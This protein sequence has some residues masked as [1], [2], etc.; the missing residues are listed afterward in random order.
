MKPVAGAA[1]E[2]VAGMPTVLPVQVLATNAGDL[3]C[4]VGRDAQCAQQAGPLP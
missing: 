4:H 3:L 2:P 1:I